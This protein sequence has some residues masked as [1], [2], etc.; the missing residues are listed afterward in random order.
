MKKISFFVL[1]IFISPLI[2]QNFSEF[3]NFRSLHNQTNYLSYKVPEEGLSLSF[4]F[5]RIF[6]SGHA[7]LENQSEITSPGKHSIFFSSRY[8]YLS[9]FFLVEI[10]PF[11]ISH[12]DLNPATKPSETFDY[13]NH[14][15]SG[16]QLKKNRMGVRQSRI[17]IHYK[18]IGLSYGKMSHWWGPGN[19][20][21]IILTSNSPSQTSYTFGTLKSLKFKNISYAFEVL[22]MPYQSQSKKQL[23]FSGINT[24]ISYNSDPIIEVGFQRSYLSGDLIRNTSTHRSKWEIND[25]LSLVFEPLF[26]R[27]KSNYDYIQDG[28]PGFDIWDQVLAAYLK[29]V[30]PKDQI[31]LFVSLASDDARGNF[32]DLKAH[33]DHTLGYQIGLQKTSNFSSFGISFLAE[34]LSLKTSNTFNPLFYRGHPNAHSF[35]TKSDYDHFTYNSRRMGAHSGTSSDDLVFMISIFNENHGYV[36]SYGKERRGIKSKIY[37]ERSNEYDFTYYINLSSRKR[38]FINIE[39]EAIDNLMFNE[40]KKS[41]SSVGWIGISYSI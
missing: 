2:A 37:P 36:L 24:K 18:Y 9:K 25:A 29:L 6:N 15:I 12:S 33:W 26:S 31:N 20:S 13:N 41:N 11:L 21:S 19:H 22:V 7:N 17:S 35:Y 30:F 34:Y 10:E 28:T 8:S 4:N 14:H 39:H 16:H 3:Y 1:N 23:Y 5:H 27:S 40:G 38:F 32:S